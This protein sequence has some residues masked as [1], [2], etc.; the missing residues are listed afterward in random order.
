MKEFRGENKDG[1][2]K[3]D[4]I[5][6]TRAWQWIP[7]ARKLGG[8]GGW[9][10]K[11]WMRKRK[12]EWADKKKT[13]RLQWRQPGREEM[14]KNTHF[15]HME[16]TVYIYIL[17]SQFQNAKAEGN[18][19][20]YIYIHFEPVPKAA[21]SKARTVFGRSNIVI[22]VS[23]PARGMDVCPRFF[24]VVLCCVVLCCPVQVEAL[25]RADPPSKESYQM[26][27]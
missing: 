13:F 18:K 7:L 6:R 2:F 3:H 19:N 5:K 12:N 14:R 26:S 1:F 4:K 9:M 16:G 10:W 23:N 20:M 15:T 21:R 17:F 22:A 24:C 11:N 8:G 25:R 27:K